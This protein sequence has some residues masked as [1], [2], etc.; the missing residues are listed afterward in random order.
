MELEDFYKTLGKISYSFSRIDFL[1]SNIAVEVDLTKSPYEFYAE[2]N[3]AEKIKKLNTGIEKIK[4]LQLRNSFLEWTKILDDIRRKRNS[5]VHSI[6]L[7]NSQD[8]NDFRLFNYK[9]TS[10]GLSKDVLEF[11]TTDFIRL[12]NDLV[13][14]NN[15]GE[16][17]LNELKSTNTQQRTVA[18]NKPFLQ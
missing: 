7:R 15:T 12:E 13:Q 14:I 2:M 3:F 18:K 6:I 10:N 5:V 8:K 9:K 11:N 4:C 1:I 17:L 16:Q